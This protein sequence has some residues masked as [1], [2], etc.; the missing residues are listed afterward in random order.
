MAP[1]TTH[2]DCPDTKG[3]LYPHDLKDR[4][5]AKRDGIVI[6]L[7]EGNNTGDDEVRLQGHQ[8]VSGGQ[9]FFNNGSEKRTEQYKELTLYCMPGLARYSLSSGPALW[10]DKGFFPRPKTKR[11]TTQQ[12]KSSWQ[13]RDSVGHILSVGFLL[14]PVLA[15]SHSATQSRTAAMHAGIFLSQSPW[16]QPEKRPF[17]SGFFLL[18]VTEF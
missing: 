4:E 3:V 8:H 14:S 15:K 9:R 12:Q 2:P 5:T 13:F 7:L 1:D 11:I 6:L 18:L 16:Q 10:I 17:E